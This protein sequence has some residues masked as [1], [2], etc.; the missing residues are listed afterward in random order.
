MLIHTRWS[1]LTFSQFSIQLKTAETSLKKLA[2]PE[3]E[4]GGGGAYTSLDSNSEV[5][6]ALAS[7]HLRDL[8]CQQLSLEITKVGYSNVILCIGARKSLYL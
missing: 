1:S 6:A 5:E 2:R 7:L 3:Q 4:E 8:R